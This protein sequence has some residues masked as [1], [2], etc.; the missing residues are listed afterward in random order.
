ML[1]SVVAITHARVGHTTRVGFERASIADLLT[2][3][4][5]RAE[6][7]MLSCLAGWTAG[8][9]LTSSSQRGVCLR[10]PRLRTFRG[11]AR[12]RSR[13]SEP[14]DLLSDRWDLLCDRR[15]GLCDG[16]SRPY[17]R[18]NCGSTCRCCV[19]VGSHEQ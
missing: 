5:W 16:E 15:D 7:V 6:A 19:I 12:G 14:V 4:A 8:L 13:P 10:I 2:V 3:D 18:G 17:K 1:R 11:G 9:L